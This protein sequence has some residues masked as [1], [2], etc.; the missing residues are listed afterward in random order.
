MMGANHSNSPTGIARRATV[1]IPRMLPQSRCHL[2]RCEMHLKEKHDVGSNLN[3]QVD[4]ECHQVVTHFVASW[5]RDSS[6]KYRDVNKH[7]HYLVLALSLQV[8]LEVHCR[9]LTSDQDHPYQRVCSLEGEGSL[10]ACPEW[11]RHVISSQRC[12]WTQ[13][14]PGKQEKERDS[15]LSFTQHHCNSYSQLV[16][17]LPSLDSE[18]PTRGRTGNQHQREAEWS[19]KP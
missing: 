5:V 8:Q 2:R 18:S 13:R 1:Y 19:T 17:F 15:S 12:Q 9:L 10:V 3:I 7:W 16:R 14:R 11:L 4:L 6:C